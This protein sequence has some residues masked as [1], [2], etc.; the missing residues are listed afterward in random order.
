MKKILVT[1]LAILLLTVLTACAD[2]R[3]R[4]SFTESVTKEPSCA[5]EGERTFSCPCG[6]SYTQAIEKL[7][8]TYKAVVS[9]PTC[10]EQGYTTYT[11]EICG[12]RN[13]D[14]YVDAPP[15]NYVNN[16][17]TLCGE[18]KIAA[19]ACDTCSAIMVHTILLPVL[20]LVRIQML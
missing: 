18:E 12:H 3:H 7:A 2:L 15:H 16:I 1:L 20:E 13:V 9:A 19:R 5:E 6:D 11:C 4:H 14:D 10:T 8:Y 17:C